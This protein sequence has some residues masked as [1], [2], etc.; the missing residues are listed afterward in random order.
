M[1]MFSSRRDFLLRAGSLATAAT[2]APKHLLAAPSASRNIRF[3][4]T[5][6]TW[7]DAEKQ[8]VDDISDLGYPGIQFRN[9]AVAEFKPTELKELLAKHNLTFVALSSGEVDLD[10]RSEA[11]EIAK[12]VANAKFVKESGGLYLQV[13][14]K[15]KSYPRSSSV[16]ECKRLGKLLSKI[17]EQT[18]DLGIPL[19]YHNHM[20][21]LGE[22]PESVDIILESSSPRFVKLQ[23]DTAHAVAGGGDPA[24]MIEKHRE[25]LLFLHLKD[26]VDYPM[27]ATNTKYPFQWVELGAGKVDIKAVFTA[28]Q[29]VDFTGWAV[30]ELDRVPDAAKTPKQCALTSRDYLERTIGAKVRK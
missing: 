18:A 21:T 12:H 15:L 16:E 2:L 24:K 17:G 23:L 14:D 10:A 7:G 19:G 3:G 29:K 30:V 25:R 26:V 4:Y 20:N 1:T 11:E 22:H 6:M 13:L 9:N 8:A 27:S 5:A 28:L